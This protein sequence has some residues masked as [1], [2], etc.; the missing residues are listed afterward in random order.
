M[1]DSSLEIYHVDENGVEVGMKQY[2]L[3]IYQSGCLV[4]EF[5]RR[6]DQPLHRRFHERQMLAI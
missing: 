5:L 1:V 3:A 4:M 6:H 2:G